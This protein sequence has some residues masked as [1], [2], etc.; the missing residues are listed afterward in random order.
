MHMRGFNRAYACV[1]FYHAIPLPL[2]LVYTKTTTIKKTELYL[3]FLCEQFLQRQCL[4]LI[5]TR[6]GD[7]NG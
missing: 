7:Y 1:R 3:I 4:E 2:C 5:H 6:F